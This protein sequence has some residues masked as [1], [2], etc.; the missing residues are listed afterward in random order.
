MRITGWIGS[1]QVRAEILA[2]RALVLPSFAEG[3]PVVLMEAM[4]LRR[5][6]ISTLVAGIPEL[7][8][9]GENGWLVPAG[10]VDALA[11]AIEACL[12][13]PADEL[14]RMAAAA[15]Q[16]VLARHAV[17]VEAGESWQ[18]V[19]CP[20]ASRCA[21]HLSMGTALTLL[22]GLLLAFALILLVPVLV[23]LIQIVAGRRKDSLPTATQARGRPS[24]AVLMPAHDEAAGIA[25]ALATVLPQL[26]ADDRLL[27]VADN[28]SDDTARIAR[29]AGAEVVERSDAHHKG[30]GYALDHGLRHLAGEAK[31]VLLIVDADCDVAPGSVERLTRECIASARP[32]QALYLMHSPP[33]A[34]LKTRISE[35]AWALRNEARP[36]GC[37]RLGWPCQLMGTG[38]A[39]FPGR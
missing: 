26:Q 19:V 28:C 16:R 31:E 25:A 15:Q 13:A 30:K 24:V 39:S 10:D 18:R 27:V 4:A 20:L 35:F 17:D 7:V 36:L 37:E 9:S 5:P 22:N 2:A 33:G 8:R 34:G 23:L 38:M 14:A 12:A 21:R 6:V 1:A 3:L 11:A 32:V 29:D